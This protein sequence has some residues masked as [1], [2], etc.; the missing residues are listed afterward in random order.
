MKAVIMAGGKGTRL[1]PLTCKIPKPMV[2][3]AARPMMEH[4]IHLLRRYSLTEI[5]VT[6]FYLPELIKNYF[7]NGADYGVSLRYFVEENPLGTAGSVKNA[8]D[9]LNE[10]FLVISGDALTDINLEA[11]I[12]FHRKKKALATLVLTKVEAPL[13]YGVV[14]TD[15]EG[16]IR[17]FLEKPGWGEVFSDTVNTG[18]YILEPEVLSYYDKDKPVDFS[19]DLFPGL[20][21][22]GE[23]LFG[24]VAD[25]YWSDVG[26]L[27][28]YRQANY[29]M[30]SGRIRLPIPGHE[31][32]PGIWAGEGA[33]IE[34]GAVLEPPVLLGEYCRVKKGARVGSLSVLGNYSF[35]EE[36]STVKRCILWNHVYLGA[37][38]EARGAI[39]ASYNHVKHKAAIYEGAVLGD[40]CTVGA[41]SLLKPGIKVWPGKY[42]ESGSV[43][44]NSLVWGS[45]CSNNLFGNLGVDKTANIELTPEFVAK[46]GAAFGTNLTE[47]HRVVVGVDNCQPAR[48][49]KQALI[50]GIMGSGI[51]VFDLGTLST[52]ATR[53]AIVTLGAEAGAHLRISPTNKENVLIEFFDGQGLN[54]DRNTQRRVEQAFFTE[55]FRRVS[56]DKMGGLAYVPRLLEDYV[57]KMLSAVDV[58]IIRNSAFK[59]MVKPDS[60]CLSILLS[61]VLEKLGCT[62]RHCEVDAAVAGSHQEEEKI[63]VVVR[64]ISAL[65]PTEDVD[66]GVVVDQNAEKLILIDEKGNRLDDRCFTALLTLLVFKHSQKPTMAVPVYASQ[67]IEKLAEKHHGNVVRTKA[68][69]RS[70][71]EMVVTEKIFP[72]QDG[73]SHFQPNFDSVFSLAKILELLAKEKM[74]LSQIISELP[75][76][77]TIQKEVQCSWEDKGRI[78]RTLFEESKEHE[79]ETTDGLKVFHDQG[80]A[81]VLPDAEDP[82]FQIYTEATSKEAADALAKMYMGRINEMQ[83]R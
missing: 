20:L 82:V 21:A 69:A 64:E 40:G 12:D 13:E 60:S 3:I 57:E 77:Y 4:I 43:V 72:G 59:V 9:F 67:A 31:I 53:F 79:I 22:K 75:S 71:M 61:T 27:E 38:T 54:I 34:H 5:G 10:T 7:G 18:I 49:L 25:G 78:M 19:K 23:P 26:N 28:Q 8:A 63:S 81:L 11:A 29:H 76:F 42:I 14:I 66:L 44:N 55:E 73:K 39:L 16:R 35:L 33:E 83:I 46:L 70:L 74:S 45:S 6:L 37:Y 52:A 80:W 36:E 2:P 48:I 47:G 17:R 24:Y 50:A 32:S 68:N 51:D 15:E 58:E 30:L 65:M 1:R 56:R 41:R 62:V